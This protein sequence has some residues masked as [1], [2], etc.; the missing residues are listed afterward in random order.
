[1]NKYE[2]IMKSNTT[3]AEKSKALAACVLEV[4]HA[5]FPVYLE[6][7][8]K[9]T[10]AVKTNTKTEQEL[11]EILDGVMNA[12]PDPREVAK[13]RKKQQAQQEDEATIKKEIKQSINNI[14]DMVL[15]ILANENQQPATPK[16][17]KELQ[18]RMHY[19]IDEKIEAVSKATDK[20]YTKVEAEMQLLTSKASVETFL[21]KG[22]IMLGATRTYYDAE[23]KAPA[24]AM[25]LELHLV[26]KAIPYHA[27]LDLSS[28]EE[29]GLVL[30]MRPDD[31][32]NP[33]TTITIEQ[34]QE[35]MLKYNKYLKVISRLRTCPV[36]AA[37]TKEM[38]D[39]ADEATK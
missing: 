17:P 14:D 23:Y 27:E 15:A 30:S 13:Q 11:E 26:D 1:M 39:L 29:S 32:E 10:D 33:D 12:L 28:E 4:V 38:A 6:A 21:D 2:E 31:E 19:I 37:F 34:L 22:L 5:D 9:L 35:E 24:K 8:M 18:A 16:I 25:W 20:L 7:M 3:R 36:L